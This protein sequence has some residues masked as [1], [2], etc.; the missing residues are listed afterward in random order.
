MLALRRCLAKGGRNA[1]MA[2]EVLQAYHRRGEPA[3]LVDEEHFVQVLN[4]HIDEDEVEV[5]RNVV[6]VEHRLVSY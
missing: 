2:R 3:T 6:E 1:Q 4:M 5:E